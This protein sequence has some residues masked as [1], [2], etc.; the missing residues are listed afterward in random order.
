MG[1]INKLELKGENDTLC[2]M[3][4]VEIYNADPTIELVTGKLDHQLSNDYTI[5]WKH[6]S[7]VGIVIKAIDKC[8]SILEL[9]IK[10][11]KR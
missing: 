5:L 4:K 8:V 11:T 2:D 9:F 1:D 6:P 3:I 7:K 10:E